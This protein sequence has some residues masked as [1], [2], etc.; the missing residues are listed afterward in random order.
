MTFRPLIDLRSTTIR[1]AFLLNAIVL[2]AV[3]TVSVEL[4]RYLDVKKETKGLTEVQ[5][6]GLTMIGTFVI[7]ILIYILTRLIFGY[8]EG[9]LASPPFSRKLL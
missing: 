3:A 8:G 4:R 5:K 2:A 1:K 7:G 6:M 9:L